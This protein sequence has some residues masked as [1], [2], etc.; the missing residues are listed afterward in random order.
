MRKPRTTTTKVAAKNKTINDDEKESLIP[1]KGK[2]GFYERNLYTL[3][4]IALFLHL[5]TFLLIL[6]LPLTVTSTLR[7]GDMNILLTKYTRRPGGDMSNMTFQHDTHL[8]LPIAPLSATFSGISAVAHLVYMIWWQEYLERVKYTGYNFVRWVEYSFSSSI[9]MLLLLALSGVVD[10]Y[11]LVLGFGC[12]FCMILFGDLSD[13]FRYFASSLHITVWDSLN[14]MKVDVLKIAKK[15]Q[16]QNE[17]KSSVGFLQKNT[18]MLLE[19]RVSEQ[20]VQRLDDQIAEDLESFE[21]ICDKRGKKYAWWSYLYG[22]I[23]WI[24]P[25]AIL[26]TAFPINV[27]EVAKQGESVPPLL[28]SIPIF[29]FLNFAMFAV[30][31]MV[32]YLYYENFIRGEF[33]YHVLS[34]SAKLALSWQIFFAV[35]VI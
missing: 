12:N 11:A 8:I 2:P 18:A 22:C 1:M 15:K 24:F 20:L 27:Q 28:Y 3:N 5:L 4:S 6:I 34:L 13:R 29:L 9:M 10:L 26:F 32:N 14:D 33:F 16:L 21:N 23:A 19:N 7:R 35:C 25:W 31:H 17:E 30:N